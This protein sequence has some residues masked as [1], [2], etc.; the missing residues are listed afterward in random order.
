MRLRSVVPLRTRCCYM[1]THISKIARID[2]AYSRSKLN[3]LKVQ[4]EHFLVFSIETFDELLHISVFQERLPDFLHSDG[5]CLVLDGWV[6]RFTAHVLAQGFQS[7]ASSDFA[8]AE[9]LLWELAKEDT[10]FMERKHCYE[11][12]VL[13]HN[14][15]FVQLIT[16]RG[17]NRV[18]CAWTV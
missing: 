1:N 8:Q 16:T 14:V 3:W 9:E 12:I 13:S 4:H 17:N 15:V 11:T 7:L 10:H 2:V 6:H 18:S 5:S